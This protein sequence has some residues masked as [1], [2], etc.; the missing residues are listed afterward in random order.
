M[1]ESRFS[2]SRL[3]RRT[4]DAVSVT[5]DSVFTLTQLGRM[6]FASNGTRRYSDQMRAMSILVLWNFSGSFK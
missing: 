4:A 3:L 5:Q 6:S 2:G 1:N